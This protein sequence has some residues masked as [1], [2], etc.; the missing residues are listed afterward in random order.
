MFDL[1]DKLSQ[2]TQ[3]TSFSEE[4]FKSLGEEKR[5]RPDVWEEIRSANENEPY[6]AKLTFMHNRLQET[7]K[8]GS[9]LPRYGNSEEFRSD[10]K[11]IY[12]SLAENKS[13]V[14]AEAFVRPLIRQIETF[15]FEFSFMDV[16]EHSAKHE[17]IVAALLE[18]NGITPG[19]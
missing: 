11:I 18:Q 15:G 17:K 9:T 12:E 5:L 1:T 16:R 8:E 13:N 19:V 14:V 6:R 2:S 7:L 3:M 10:L 4:L